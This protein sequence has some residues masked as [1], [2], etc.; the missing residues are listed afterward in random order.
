MTAPCECDENCSCENNAQSGSRG[1][2]SSTVS[3]RAPSEQST[4]APDDAEEQPL[5]T[6]AA[7]EMEW[8]GLKFKQISG[9]AYPSSFKAEAMHHLHKHFSLRSGDVVL[10]SHWPVTGLQR[11]LVSLVEGRLDPWEAGLISK[12]YFLEA[13]ASKRGIQ[14]YL[15][16]VNSWTGRRCFK[17]HSCPGMTPFRWP[18]EAVLAGDQAG[19]IPPKVV[20]FVADPRY[21]F[22][23][24]W[25]M[26]KTKN[27]CNP[28]P[29]GLELSD[30][31]ETI[32]ESRFPIFGNYFNHALAWA[33]EALEHP[34][35]VRLFSAERFASHNPQD[36]CEAV[37]ELAEFLEVPSASEV[38][39]QLV[40]A[41]V[42][43]PTQDLAEVFKE[44]CLKPLDAIN[45]GP[46]IELVGPRLQAFQ[47]GLAISST[48]V[49]AN[50]RSMLTSWFDAPS[51]CLAQL[52]ESAARGVATLLPATLSRPWKGEAVHMEGTCR[53]CVF[54]L[55]GIC[56]NS[57]EMCA[58]CHAD[59]HQPTKRAS[60]K[61]RAKRKARVYTP[62]PDGLSS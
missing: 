55:R 15:S 23:L 27:L 32:V 43:L 37:T 60:R 56:R 25:E 10:V 46:M 24:S 58:Y 14:N 48:K 33:N 5:P 31:I 20:V 2:S 49:Q 17:S 7:Q 40:S 29:V 12:P 53:P 44:D 61:T 3:D 30:F 13:G 35:N 19:G 8:R 16:D 45:G 51:I 52:G 54:H 47:E 57:D 9:I 1:V 50:F 18:P 59:G 62:S 34:A 39:H 6:I 28:M 41:L 36:V 21:A 11:L 26:Y 4:E 22:A 42:H 38:A